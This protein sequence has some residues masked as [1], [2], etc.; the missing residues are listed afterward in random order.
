MG[1]YLYV[2]PEFLPYVQFHRHLIKEGEIVWFPTYSLT[3]LTCLLQLVL[4]VKELVTNL[5]TQGKTFIRLF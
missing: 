3:P 5:Q 2:L 4:D 1:G